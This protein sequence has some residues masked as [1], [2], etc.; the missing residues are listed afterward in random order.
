M[1]NNAD[2]TMLKIVQSIFLTGFFEFKVF[3]Q[4]L[5]FTNTNKQ[6]ES[7]EKIKI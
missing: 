7:I 4:I 1:L 5:V 2:G 6:F 3:T